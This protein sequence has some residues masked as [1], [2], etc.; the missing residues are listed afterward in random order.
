MTDAPV[1]P[2]WIDVSQ[3][4]DLRDVIHRAV[5]CL[6]QGGVVGLATETVYGLA[7]SALHPAS[8]ATVR[9]AGGADP[10]R[11]LTLLLKGPAEVTDWVPDIS[12]V[13]RRMSSRLWPGPVTLV[14]SDC[15][16]KGLCSR[17]PDA[18]K[19]FVAPRGDVALRCPI[20][21][22]VRDVLKLLPAPLV[23]SAGPT[24]EQSIPVTADALRGIAGLDMVI[25]A[26]PTQ[27]QRLSTIIRIDD[28]RWTLE[29]EGAVAAAA[30]SQSS[31]V[32]ILFVCTGNTCRSPMAE[33][34]CKLILTRRLRC[35]HDEISNRGFVV[36]SAGIATSS[37]LPAAAHAIDVVRGLGGSLENHRSRK[38]GVNLVRQADYIFAMTNDHR[39]ALVS[40]VP[41]AEPRAFLLDPAGDDVADPVGC[42]FDTYRRTAQMIESMLE[43]RLDQMGI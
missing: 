6:A 37:G 19:S 12:L 17:L 22:F 10:A 16:G 8:V 9:R 21:L 36:R 41:D 2:Q 13:G 34:L 5:A 32:I 30:I 7:A 40:A 25:D 3:A 15:L 38:I 35:S 14:F 23:I 39:E 26:G 28:D 18:V 20:G 42:D 24:N 33:A 11:P 27:Y 29:R 4:D 1:S 31:S 43:E